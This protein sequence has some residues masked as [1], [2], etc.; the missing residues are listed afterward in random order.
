M[1]EELIRRLSGWCNLFAPSCTHFGKIS[2][3]A[4]LYKRSCLTDPMEDK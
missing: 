3:P 2:M 4:V 1:M